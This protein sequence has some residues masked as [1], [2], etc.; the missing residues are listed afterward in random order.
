MSYDE[1]T[2]SVEN[3]QDTIVQVKP[4][5]KMPRMPNRKERRAN[6]SLMKKAQDREQK[7]AKSRSKHYA[8]LQQWL[9][10]TELPKEHADEVF[11]RVLKKLFKKDYASEQEFIGAIHSS[12]R[13]LDYV[14]L[15]SIDSASGVKD[16]SND[17]SG[18]VH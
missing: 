10:K 16:E 6:A 18:T 3:K 2:G 13:S 14:P 11:K 9:A 1:T 7:M 4:E 17:E 8:T 5:P 15:G 12:I